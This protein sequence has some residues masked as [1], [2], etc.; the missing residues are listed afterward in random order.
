M[1][2][3]LVEGHLRSDLSVRGSFGHVAGFDIV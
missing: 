3:I 2:H 1:T